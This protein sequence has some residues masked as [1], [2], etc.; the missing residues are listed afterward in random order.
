MCCSNIVLTR[1]K[2]YVVGHVQLICM[3]CSAPDRVRWW[4]LVIMV[5]NH[6]VL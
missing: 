1:I 3:N 6:Q 4:S 2:I 5:L